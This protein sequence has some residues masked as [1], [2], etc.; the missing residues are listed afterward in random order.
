MAGG[1]GVRLWPYSRERRPKQFIHIIGDGTMIQETVGR[2]S[3]L[4]APEDIFIVTGPDGEELVREQLPAIPAE[5]I[6]VEPFG[7]NTAPCIA[8]AACIIEERLGED[9]VMAVFPSDHLI[10]NVGEFQVAVKTAADVAEQING[11]VT[12]GVTPTRPETGFGYIQIEDE[13]EGER[14]A[15]Y[16]RGLRLMSNFAE[17][18]DIETA[19][20]FLVAGDFL[21]NSGIFVWKISIIWE[22]FAKY[23][24]DHYPLF[25]LLKKHVA[26]DSY[27]ETLEN[28]YRQ[29]RNISLDYGIMEKARDMYVL[30]VSFGWSDV[31]TWDEVHRL[32]LKDA[33]DNVI[34][35]NVITIDSSNC[36]ISARD[37]LISTVG[38]SDLII[39]ETDDT[40]MICKRSESQK[41]KEIIDFLR[42]K[43]INHFL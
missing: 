39:I 12:L 23:L 22:A 25:Q 19:K 42:R 16:E 1:Y 2:L 15:F 27:A 32:R 38:V 30:E 40:I 5:N 10:M 8:L 18:P 43:R 29:M 20:R 17:K 21:W 26:K 7:R 28:V 13:Q 41:V 11:V 33:Q 14:N 6:I 4:F 34:D 31:G 36:L 37:K 35:G 24:P 3:P 9:A